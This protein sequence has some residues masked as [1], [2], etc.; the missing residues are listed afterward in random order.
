MNN[1]LYTALFAVVASGAITVSAINDGR[2][3]LG[4]ENPVTI[5]E[6]VPAPKRLGGSPSTWAPSEIENML[7]RRATAL[8]GLSHRVSSELYELANALSFFRQNEPAMF[9]RYFGSIKTEPLATFGQAG[10]FIAAV[11]PKDYDDSGV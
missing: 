4:T 11:A 9:Q 1:K 2:G 6:A 10:S 5:T 3:G 7:R 8:V